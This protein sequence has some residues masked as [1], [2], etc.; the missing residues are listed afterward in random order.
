MLVFPRILAL[1]QWDRKAIMC[2]HLADTLV[3]KNPISS[4]PLICYSGMRRNGIFCPASS[5]LDRGFA[6]SL[7]NPRCPH[8]IIEE[9][10]KIGRSA[11]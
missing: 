3:L 2:K 1:I 10:R 8:F 4:L 6:E 11:Y 7:P 5:R 9:V